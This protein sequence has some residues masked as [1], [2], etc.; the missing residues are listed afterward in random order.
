METGRGGSR[1]GST[2]SLLEYILWLI[3]LGIDPEVAETDARGY[4]D[5][6]G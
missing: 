4:V 2:M 3:S 1:E 5:P 6:N